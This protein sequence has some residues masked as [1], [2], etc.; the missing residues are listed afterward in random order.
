LKLLADV[1]EASELLDDDAELLGPD[2]VA[3]VV[4]DGLKNRHEV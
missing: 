3:T 4:A 2:D 1:E